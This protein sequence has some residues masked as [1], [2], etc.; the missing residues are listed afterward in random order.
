MLNDKELQL[1]ESKHLAK[2]QQLAAVAQAKKDAEKV[3]KALKAE[4][5]EQFEKYGIDKLSNDYINITLIKASESKS[6]DLKAFEDAEPVEYAQ[7]LV[8]YPKIT[9][10]SS[11]L[12]FTLPKGK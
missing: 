10:R 11:Y 12:K 7:L 3:E 4:L 6:I 5:L 1:F 8:D 9:K 2:F